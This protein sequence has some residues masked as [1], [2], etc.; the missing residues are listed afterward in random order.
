MLG[1]NPGDATKRQT[2]LGKALGLLVAIGETPDSAGATV[3]ELMRATGLSRPTTYRFLGELLDMGMVVADPRAPLWRL[4]PK[5]IALAAVAGNLTGLRRRARREMESF[6]ARIGHTVHLGIRDGM[7]IVYIDK[8][9]SSRNLALA[10]SVGQ[11]RPLNVTALGKCLVAFDSNKDLVDIVA[12]AGLRQRTR[13]SITDA[14][15]WRREIESVRSQG[16]AFDMEE[17]DTG[18][19][20]IAAPIRD[21][22]GLAV[23]AVSLSALTIGAGSLDFEELAREIVEVAERIGSTG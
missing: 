5:I 14:E 6:V 19:R 4:G 10:S 15:A 8:A 21:S 18:A 16:F 11:R 23:A 12:D 9:E 2:S 1:S 3:V 22:Q 13:K 7:E 17:C 20:C